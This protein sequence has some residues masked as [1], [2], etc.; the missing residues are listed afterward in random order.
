MLRVLALHIRARLRVSRTTLS[1]SQRGRRGR[2]GGVGRGHIRTAGAQRRVCGRRFIPGSLQRD[3]G[4]LPLGSHAR[5]FLLQRAEWRRIRWNRALE[6]CER[7]AR[8]QGLLPPARGL[9]GGGG[10]LRLEHGDGDG[11]LLGLHAS[12]VERQGA[13]VQQRLLAARGVAEGQQLGGGA[14][15]REG[16]V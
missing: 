1:S 13:V 4:G 14:R 15:L 3:G 16:P 11:R 12:G 7:F 6:L 9:C 10:Q 5:H 8:S 2:S